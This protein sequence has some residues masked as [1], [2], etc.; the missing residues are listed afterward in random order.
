VHLK[1]FVRDV[2]INGIPKC[3]IR[4]PGEI[5]IRVSMPLPQTVAETAPCYDEKPPPQPSPDTEP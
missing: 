4:D 2:T 3:T 1:S 5:D